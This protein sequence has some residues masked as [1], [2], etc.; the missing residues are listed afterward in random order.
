LLGGAVGLG[1]WLANR[2]AHSFRRRVAI[3]GGVGGVVG[4]L[5]PLAG[6]RLMA[7]S[8]DLLARNVPGSRLRIDAIGRAFGEIGLGPIGQSATGA[9][10][11]ALFAA[12]IV[13]A[14]MR[15]RRDLD[16]ASPR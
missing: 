6:G 13:A 8:L 7:G 3:A 1:G 4:A 15:A 5:I 9:L 12:C 11:G 10:E 16:R 2:G 14:M